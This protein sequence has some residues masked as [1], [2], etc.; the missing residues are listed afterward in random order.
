MQ[1]RDVGN[2]KK[3]VENLDNGYINEWIERLDLQEIYSKVL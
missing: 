1:I 2:I 3:V